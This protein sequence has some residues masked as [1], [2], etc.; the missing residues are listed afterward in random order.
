[1]VAADYKHWRKAIVHR[2]GEQHV[3]EDLRKAREQFRY[4]ARDRRYGKV[5]GN[6]VVTN[7][8][9]EVINDT[10]APHGNY[11]RLRYFRNKDLR[12]AFLV[13]SGTYNAAMRIRVSDAEA[14][15]P[16]QFSI[17]VKDG[18]NEKCQ[19]VAHFAQL[20]EKFDSEWLL[21][22]FP[23][24][25]VL[26]GC[27]TSEKVHLQLSA[28]KQAVIDC[29]RVDWFELVP[30]T[31]APQRPNDVP[32]MTKLQINEKT[33]PPLALIALDSRGDDEDNLSTGGS[34]DYNDYPGG[35]DG[36]YYSRHD[37]YDEY[38]DDE[39]DDDEFGWYRY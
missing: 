21:V 27:G 4:W 22:R 13:P 29:L 38:Y 15:E 37:Y 33:E 9:G 7:S 32:D 16:F 26:E 18:D 14:H 19:Q 31:V 30:A 20:D 25:I 1:M 8:T 34:S 12:G 5:K 17:R 39:Y 36:D 35:F 3:P 28:R 23:L 24:P 6:L 2:F 10:V 11:L